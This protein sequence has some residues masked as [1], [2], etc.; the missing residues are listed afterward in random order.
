MYVTSNVAQ[1]RPQ[2]DHQ[3]RKHTQLEK[4]MARYHQKNK[5]ESANHLRTKRKDESQGSRLI[6]KKSKKKSTTQFIPPI[7]VL[8]QECSI[9][10]NE[11][12]IQPRL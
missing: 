8:G 12:K 4:N 5:R 3:G 7:P 2:I 6:S 1:W 10:R 11:K 9:G